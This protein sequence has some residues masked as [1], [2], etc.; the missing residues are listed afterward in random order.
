MANITVA[1]SDE[2]LE[3]AQAKLRELGHGAIEQF[4]T[5]ALED[6]ADI[7]APLDA[8]L[9]AKLLEGL[10]SPALPVDEAFWASVDDH[11][12]RNIKK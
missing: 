7:D 6:L 2:I 4:L 8:D 11:I 3:T 10:D 5:Q 9:E 12:D 1:I